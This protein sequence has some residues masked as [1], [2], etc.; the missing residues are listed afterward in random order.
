M[1]PGNTGAEL[2]IEGRPCA[3]TITAAEIN[4]NPSGIRFAFHLTGSGREYLLKI[5]TS[6]P[7]NL[8]YW[9]IEEDT[10]KGKEGANEQAQRLDP[11]Q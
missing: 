10:K 9:T 3:L 8:F 2:T 11:Q 7:V 5:E 4:S 6:E 1:R